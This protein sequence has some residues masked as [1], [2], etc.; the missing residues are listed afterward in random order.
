MAAVFFPLAG[1]QDRLA[2]CCDVACRDTNA[3]NPHGTALPAHGLA[4][5]LCERNER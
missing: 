4:E 1:R 2:A 3:G 5:V